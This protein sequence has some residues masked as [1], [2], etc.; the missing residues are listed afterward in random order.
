MTFRENLHIA[1]LTGL[2]AL[3][4]TAVYAKGMDHGERFEKI[5]ADGDG[6]IT[7][8]EM[9]AYAE[10]RFY[11][12]LSRRGRLCSQERR[13]LRPETIHEM[14]APAPRAG[15]ADEGPWVP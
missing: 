3:G 11:L 4:G 15:A 8:P 13:L 6:Q 5:D 1:A 10:A 14:A 7:Q 9:M 12:M 2:I